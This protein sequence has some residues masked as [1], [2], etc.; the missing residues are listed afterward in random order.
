MK[1]YHFFQ[2]IQ[3]FNDAAPKN[4]EE[5]IQSV[6]DAYTN[7]PKNKLCALLLLLLLCFCNSWVFVGVRCVFTLPK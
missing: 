3:S 2:A 1:S 4:K 7:Y 5:L 6:H